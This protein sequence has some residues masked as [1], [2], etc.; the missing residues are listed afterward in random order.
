MEPK[1]PFPGMNP[2]LEGRGDVHTRLASY[3]ADMLQAALPTD[4]RARIEERVYIESF[5]ERRTV[6]PEVYVFE[7]RPSSAR[8]QSSSAGVAVAEPIMLPIH[9][10]EVTEHYIRIIDAIRRS[11]DHHDRIHQSLE[12]A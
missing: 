1:N 5:E 9:A 3:S 12:Q 2:Y 4:L 8:G 6:R 11:C 7:E 10:V